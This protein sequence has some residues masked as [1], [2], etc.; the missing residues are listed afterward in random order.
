MNGTSRFRLLTSALAAFAAILGSS[1]LAAAD[2]PTTIDFHDTRM[3]A[4]P[5]LSARQVA[6][7]YDNDIWI[8]DLGVASDAARVARRLTSHEGY[9]YR[10]RFS[11]DGTMVAFSGEYDGNVDVYVMSVDGGSPR[12]LTWHPGRDEVEGFTPDGKSILFTSPRSV[13]TGRF[14][15]LFTVPVSGG[16][17]TRLPIPNGLHASYAPD[18]GAIA[19]QPLAEVHEQWKH[20]RGGATARIWLYD[21]AK[22]TVAQVP[23]PPDRSNDVDPMWIGNRIYFRSD[24]NGEINLFSF[25][26]SSGEV[27]QLTAFTDFPVLAA[28]AEGSGDGS[29]IAF[30]QAGWVH[31]LD[32]KTGKT[33]RLRIGAASDLKEVRPRFEKGKDFVRDGALSPS[34][35]RAVLEFRGEILTVP[36]EK[37]APRNLTRTTGVHERSPAWSPDGTRIAWFTDATGEYRLS[38]APQ[39][40]SGEARSYDLEGAGFYQDMQWSPDGRYISYTD[41][42]WTLYLLDLT[43]RRD[44]ED[45]EPAPLRAGRRAQSLPLLVARLQ[46]AGLHP[47]DRRLHRAGLPVL[48]GRE[49]PAIR[50]PT[51]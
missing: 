7:A 25:D 30:E 26:R 22:K 38:V 29:R 44:R 6:F 20:Y 33:E 15:Q 14:V 31:V 36:A 41:N 11:P 35:A 18:G 39:D 10:P 45:R 46:V 2:A 47:A 9:E 21:F 5:A 1:A 42:S 12:R 16:F 3:L 19:Y 34:G 8:A 40:G 23:Q 17:P 32:T 48:G 27:K 4:Q 28:S 13:Y 50:S 49:E 37:G 51:A 24:R 43:T